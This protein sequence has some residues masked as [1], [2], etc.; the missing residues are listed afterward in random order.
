MVENSKRT[1]QENL[2]NV[3]WY[4]GQNMKKRAKRHATINTMKTSK[5]RH[6]KKYLLSITNA[7]WER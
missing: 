6:A 5:S 3:L 4:I 2:Q 1:T 7:P